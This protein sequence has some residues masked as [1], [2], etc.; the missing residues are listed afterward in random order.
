MNISLESGPCPNCGQQNSIHINACHNCHRTL[1][2]AGSQATQVLTPEV[3][4]E[5]RK[6]EQKSA[7]LSAMLWQIAGCLVILLGLFL[8]FGNVFTVYRTFPGAGYFTMAFGGA[9]LS[10]GIQKMFDA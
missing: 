8:W 7:K 5:Q 9:I 6:R 4:A 10:R 3:V 2:W 1:P